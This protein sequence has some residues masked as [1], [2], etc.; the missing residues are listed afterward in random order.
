[1]E[2]CVAERQGSAAAGS[3][4]DGGAD[5]GGSQLQPNVRLGMSP[6]AA[7]WEALGPAGPDAPG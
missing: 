5:A 4:S 3:G 7:K 1:M 2:L 6:C